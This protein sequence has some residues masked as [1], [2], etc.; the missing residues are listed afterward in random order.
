MTCMRR[1]SISTRQIGYSIISGRMTGLSV[2]LSG[3][4][5]TNQ[6]FV[7]NQVGAPAKD[8]VKYEKYGPVYAINVRYK[9]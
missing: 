2:N 8:I 4:N 7:L 5:L 6:P 1:I 9:F 3:S